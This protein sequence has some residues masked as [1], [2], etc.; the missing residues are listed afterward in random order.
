MPQ[1]PT[2]PLPILNH[3]I[4]YLIALMQ[5]MDDFLEIMFAD[6]HLVGTAMAR[7]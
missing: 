3:A 1:S 6:Q 5:S 4:F 2:I 7:L